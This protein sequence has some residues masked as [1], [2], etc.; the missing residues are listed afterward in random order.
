MPASRRPTKTAN[1]T[2]VT[3]RLLDGTTVTERPDVVPLTISTRAPGKWAFVDLETGEAW[4]IDEQLRFVR[5]SPERME[6]IAALS[7]ASLR[8]GG[9]AKRG[10]RAC[11]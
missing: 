6:A 10:P 3:R 5:A 9:P 2:P 1:S 7:E 4:C 11:N 8:A